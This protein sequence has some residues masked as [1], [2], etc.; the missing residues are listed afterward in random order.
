[1][2]TKPNNRDKT[3]DKCPI[4]GIAEPGDSTELST[5]KLALVG[6]PQ[7]WK[8]HL[9]SALNCKAVTVGNLAGVTMETAVA[10][11]KF[12]GGEHWVVHDFPG[13]YNLHAQSEDGQITERSLLD[14]GHPHRP[15][16]VLLVADVNALQGQLFLILQIRELG[17]PC[18]V[19][20]NHMHPA[21]PSRSD[22]DK[23]ANHLERARRAC[24]G[25]QC[26]PRQPQGLGGAVD[27]I[28]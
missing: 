19:L 17:I 18:I 2:A 25:R 14:L 3:P 15:D 7:H 13:L 16:V 23:Q 28:V 26:P 10:P 4:W 11:C 21:G 5:V 22:L 24:D 20:L 1:M 9:V 12:Q 8:I 6:N 27:P